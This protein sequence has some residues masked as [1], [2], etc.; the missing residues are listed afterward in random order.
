MEQQFFSLTARNNSK[1]GSKSLGFGEEKKQMGPFL[2]LLLER[3][4]YHFI[5]ISH[6]KL[7]AMLVL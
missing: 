4:S 5:R 2:Q 1:Q 7:F 3:F 6:L